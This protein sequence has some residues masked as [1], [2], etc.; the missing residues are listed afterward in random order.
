M[1]KLI[2]M[3]ENMTGSLWLSFMPLFIAFTVTALVSPLLIPWL[4]KL[5][6]GQEILE[7]GP[8]WHKSKEGTPTMGGISFILGITVAMLLTFLV[9]RDLPLLMLLL[10]SLGFGLIGFTDDYIKVVKKRNLGLTARQKFLLQTILSVIYIVVLAKT[11]NL[12]NHIIIPFVRKTVEIPWILYLI[13]TVF[14]V[15]GTVNAVNL[16]DGIDGLAT[17]IT[18]IVT[19]FFAIAAVMLSDIAS[20]WFSLA[21]LGGCMAFYMF[22]KHPAKMFMGDTGSLFLGGSISVLAVGQ[23]MPLILVIVGFVYLFETLSVIIQVTS[24]KLTGKRVFKMTPIHHHFEMCGWKENKI[25][26]VFT[27]VTVILCIIGIFAILPYAR[28]I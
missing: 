7:I 17:S 18:A 28:C 22:N 15:T 11:G 2:D 26:S 21:V 24:F 19:L 20:M 1:L 25:V 8:S 4:K 10:I 12:N 16:T 3:S 9:K 27:A 6:F 5:K 23:K 13:L 14:V